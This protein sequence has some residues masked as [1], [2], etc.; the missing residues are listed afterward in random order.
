MLQ[1]AFGI[2]FI[3]G[4]FDGHKEFSMERPAHLAADVIRLVGKG[5]LRFIDGRRHL[6]GQ[7]IVSAALYELVLGSGAPR[8]EFVGAISAAEVAELMEGRVTQGEERWAEA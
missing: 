1:V 6:P 4:P 8:Y 2:E 3:G 7:A 5:V